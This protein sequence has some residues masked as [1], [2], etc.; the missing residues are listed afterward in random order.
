MKELAVRNF[1]AALDNAEWHGLDEVVYMLVL[2]CH[3]MGAGGI[4]S[5]TH[6]RGHGMRMGNG[7]TP[8]L[9]LEQEEEDQAADALE[10]YRE[11]NP[12]SLPAARLCVE[13]GARAGFD[14]ARQL[15][16]CTDCAALDSSNAAVVARMMA[17]LARAD[18]ADAAAYAACCDAAGAVVLDALRTAPRRAV[19]PW[20]HLASLAAAQRLGAHA[21]RVADPHWQAVF[22][23][24][25][26]RA[27]RTLT[28]RAHTL[29][30]LKA[31][32]CHHA[33]GAAAPLARAWRVYAHSLSPAGGD[34]DDLPELSEPLL[35]L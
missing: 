22:L 31:H 34:P 26:R 24:V 11:S 35:A 16:A 3:A 6:A 9:L 19:A 20:H 1:N 33:F 28:E 4:V 13:L 30:A 17:L 21:A 14:A 23:A 32:F 25:P 8:Q 7:G 29:A 18:R 2:V 27:P 12:A 10:R 15:R 5:N